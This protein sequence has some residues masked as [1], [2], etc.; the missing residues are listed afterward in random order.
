VEERLMM[1][2]REFFE[3]L[4]QIVL[5][6]NKDHNIDITRVGKGW[7]LEHPE[8]SKRIQKFFLHA[9]T[10]NRDPDEVVTEILRQTGKGP[11]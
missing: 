3:W 10:R 1:P 7:Y 8:A 6:L 2:T 9:Y 4:G 11:A 5:T